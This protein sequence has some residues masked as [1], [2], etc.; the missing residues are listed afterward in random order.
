MMFLTNFIGQYVS[1]RNFSQSDRLNFG[2]P[3]TN[4]YWLNFQPICGWLLQPIIKGSEP[5]TRIGT[6]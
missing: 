4:F 3:L 6:I 5:P 2:Y 1:N